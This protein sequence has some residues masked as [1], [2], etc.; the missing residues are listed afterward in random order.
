MEKNKIK[1]EI[2]DEEEPKF[3]EINI[4]EKDNDESE[5]ELGNY[6]NEEKGADDEISSDDEN[7]KKNKK[8]IKSNKNKKS[9]KDKKEKVI[10]PFSLVKVK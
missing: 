4:G 9:K 3:D 10:C 5:K 6:M 7:K 1:N 2:K 8:D